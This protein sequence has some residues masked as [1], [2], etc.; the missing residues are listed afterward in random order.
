[1]RRMIPALIAF[2]L[3]TACAASEPEPERSALDDIEFGGPHYTKEDEAPRQP[4]VQQ[5][6]D[7]DT[8]NVRNGNPSAGIFFNSGIEAGGHTYD[9]AGLNAE[10]HHVYVRQSDRAEVVL[11]PGG[12]FYQRGYW[13]VPGTEMTDEG[14]WV[15]L[16]AMLY[17]AREV[18]NRQVA[19]FIHKQKGVKYAKGR[20]TGPDGKAWAVDHAWGLRISEHGAGVQTGFDNHPAVGCSG[21][22][23]LA[24][25]RW[26]GGDLPTAAEF[27]KAA[28]G[29][30]GLLFPWGNEDKLPD[31][32]RANSYLHG[33]KR[34]TAVGSY[35]A[36]ASPYGLLD[37]AGNV[38]ERAYW[39][40]VPTADD[41]LNTRLPTML[42]GG[43]WVSPN[44]SNLRCVCRCGQNMD[45]MDGSVG[46]RV[47]VRDPEIL[48][49]FVAEP[50]K[51]RVLTD[52]LDAY[53]EAAERNVP[54]F[55][56]MGYERCGQCDRV[57][58]QI[59]TDP[60]FVDYCNRHMVVLAGI[61]RREF[62]DMPKTPLADGD[63]YFAGLHAPLIELEQVWEDFSL[64]RSA[65]YVPLPDSLCLF[66]ISPGMAVLNPHR[67][68]VRNP[69]DAVLVNDDAFHGRKTGGGI[70]HYLALFRLAQAKLGRGL[71]RAEHEAGVDVPETAWR[72][73]PEDAALWE[74][75][76][77]AMSELTKVL[78]MYSLENEGE[79]PETLED[80]R[81]Y[82]ERGILPQD[83]FLSD[84]FRYTRTDE[85]FELKCFG[86]GD[87]P[88][89]DEIPDKDIVFT[90]EGRQD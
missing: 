4:R 23:A 5:F 74:R 82:F 76:R 51:L 73:T 9:V 12:E 2:A 11:I 89:G 80:V 13:D 22:L 30:S 62:N 46:F 39:G 26:V 28:G 71:T 31:S 67:K 14:R 68:L 32:T 10:G 43:S 15:H 78:Q 49:Q 33:P 45:A 50:P 86:R 90:E 1:M 37:M 70:D 16:P 84:Y 41:D 24:Y 58:A 18:T 79:Y 25:A 83:P 19:D 88:G 57:L 56:F 64:W 63:M 38:Y 60:D 20:V 35:P 69:T 29:P 72:P 53:N 40:E 55:L 8:R 66:R 81:N 52:T 59:F 36:G 34:T 61:N 6:F 47:V 21:W 77:E 48:K 3:I 27:E 54:I 44:W 87:E 17:D 75:T 65:H 42:K 7:E 85:G